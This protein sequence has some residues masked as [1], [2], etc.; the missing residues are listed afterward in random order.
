MAALKRLLKT[1]NVDDEKFPPRELA[2]FI[3]AHK[4][5]GIRAA[6]AEI[7]DDYTR[8]RVEL[9]AE[10]EAQCQR[11]W[12]SGVAGVGANALCWGHYSWWLVFQATHPF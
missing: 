2:S 4:E 6:Q 7:Y 1:L 12:N 8:R 9:Y 5:Q 11:D 3:N 10:C